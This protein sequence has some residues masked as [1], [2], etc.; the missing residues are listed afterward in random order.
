MFSYS[1]ISR[2][3]PFKID[4]LTLE[5]WLANRDYFGSVDLP[6]SVDAD[7]EA[8][9][10]IESLRQN[11][12]SGTKDLPVEVLLS[13]LEL[14]GSQALAEVWVIAPKGRPK[15]KEKTA[16]NLEIMEDGNAKKV[17][18]APLEIMFVNLEKDKNYNVKASLNGD[19]RIED[20]NTITITIS[21]CTR[22]I[23]DTRGRPIQFLDSGLQREKN[24]EWKEAF[25]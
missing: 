2:W 20:K 6:G 15:V 17:E 9:Y 16:L 4:P 18:V 23:I 13:G 25:K 22:L 14:S 5:D 8:A 21:Q 1:D 24:K 10:L 12:I 11:K 7:L 3:L 19:L